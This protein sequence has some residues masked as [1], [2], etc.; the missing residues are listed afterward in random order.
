ME[1]VY[2]VFGCRTYSS[3]ASWSEVALPSDAVLE[4]PC[5]CFSARAELAT[6]KPL[7]PCT[8]RGAAHGR[9]LCASFAARWEIG[10]PGDAVLEAPCLCFSTRAGLV[11]DH[12][13]CPVLVVLPTAAELAHSLRLVQRLPFRVMLCRSPVPLLFCADGVGDGPTPAVLCSWCCPW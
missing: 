9:S 3:F 12:P 8:R 1:T 13:S 11:M 5:L 2:D 7:L 10:P 4:A 6:G